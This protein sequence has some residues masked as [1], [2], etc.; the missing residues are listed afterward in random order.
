MHDIY[1]AAIIPLAE[2]KLAIFTLP[3]LQFLKECCKYSLGV[4]VVQ[5]P[6]ASTEV[7]YLNSH[8]ILSPQNT[9]NFKF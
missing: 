1:T 9:T 8:N 4:N 3:S 2:R 7:T 5:L 6:P